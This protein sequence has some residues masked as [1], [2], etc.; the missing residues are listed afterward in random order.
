[1]GHGRLLRTAGMFAPAL[2]LSQTPAAEVHAATSRATARQGHEK[3]IGLHCGFRQPVVAP[4]G[5]RFDLGDARELELSFGSRVTA[6]RLPARLY[7]ETAVVRMD[8]QDPD[9]N[10]RVSGT[11]ALMRAIDILV[12]VADGPISLPDLVQKVNIPKQTCHRIATA[13][14]ERGLLLTSGRSGYRLGPM[15]KELARRSET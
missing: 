12:A 8:E 9:A 5:F 11:Q 13:L 10:Q 2:A 15:I 4:W 1:M 14:A 6:T 3:A 7:P